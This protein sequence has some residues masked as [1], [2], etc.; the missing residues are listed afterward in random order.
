VAAA[1]ELPAADGRAA[2][3]EA[4]KKRPIIGRFF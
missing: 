1:K 3:V 4:I 2:G